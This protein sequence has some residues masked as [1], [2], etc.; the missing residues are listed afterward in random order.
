MFFTKVGVC[1]KCPAC[2]GEVGV[3]DDI[4]LKYVNEFDLN[5]L[6]G[7]LA[8]GADDSWSGTRNFF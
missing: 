2:G 6:G 3:R 7:F 4:L 1:R 8:L 5:E